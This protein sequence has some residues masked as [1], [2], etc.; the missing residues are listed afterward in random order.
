MVVEVRRG[1]YRH[2]ISLECPLCHYQFRSPKILPCYHSFCEACLYAVVSAS[3][4]K[5][6]SGTR[7]FSCPTCRAKTEIQR[8]GVHTLQTNFVLAAQ[9]I[10]QNYNQAK[11]VCAVCMLRRKPTEDPVH[12]TIKCW[13]CDKL[14]CTKCQEVHR[15]LLKF[16]TLI[17][18]SQA[19]P[20][21]VIRNRYC[22]RHPE[23]QLR[24]YCLKCED[25]ICRDCRMT[26]H[27][28]GHRTLDMVDL[29]QSAKEL[30]S[31]VNEVIVENFIPVLETNT[32]FFKKEL[33]EKRV[34]KA[35]LV[36]AIAKREKTLLKLVHEAAKEAQDNLNDTLAQMEEE[37]RRYQDN[38]SRIHSETEYNE[39]VIESGC[40]ADVM[41]AAMNM[42]PYANTQSPESC[43]INIISL[44]QDLVWDH[45]DTA[46][47]HQHHSANS[48]DHNGGKEPHVYSLK[49]W[50]HFADQYLGRVS[51]HKNKLTL[52]LSQAGEESNLVKCFRKIGLLVDSYKK[53]YKKI[54]STGK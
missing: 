20:V 7:F 46:A 12:A 48:G 50:K 5:S 49:D 41:Q 35:T 3:S 40:E 44:K 45:K 9:V 11:P 16:H 32:V 17:Q 27:A 21:K 52:S 26:S 18:L 33:E 10:R 38:L 25:T 34:T 36:E 29:Q 4:V 28:E 43:L 31:K 47:F 19:G 2:R 8:G 39:M 24:F 22:G 13:E 37:S 53:N 6:P 14:L 30:V 54:A 15:T 1:S 42:L 23:E 51:L